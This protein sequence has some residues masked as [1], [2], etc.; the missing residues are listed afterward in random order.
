MGNWGNWDNLGGAWGVAD[1]QAGGMSGGSGNPIQDVQ[2]DQE[3]AMARQL[4]LRKRQKEAAAGG[5]VGDVT[6]DEAAKMLGEA[7]AA[8]QESSGGGGIKG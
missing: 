6:K 5:N 1:P 3:S 8:Q 2:R 4:E 7:A